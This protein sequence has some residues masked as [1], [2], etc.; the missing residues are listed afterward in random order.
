MLM[1]HSHRNRS[2]TKIIFD[3]VETI[4]HGGPEVQVCKSFVF[5][6]HSWQYIF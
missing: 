5:Q 4:V 2:Q 6:G 1:T 3:L